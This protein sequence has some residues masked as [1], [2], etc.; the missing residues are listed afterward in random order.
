MKQLNIVCD[1]I[2]YAEFP[3]L[4]FGLDE[5]GNAY[6]DVD[7]YLQDNKLELTH[8]IIKFQ[9][10]FFYFLTKA[11]SAYNLKIEDIIA[12]NP[13]NE[14]HLLLSELALLFVMYTDPNFMFYVLDRIDE[15]FTSGITMS[16]T[17]L[18]QL[19]SNR[20]GIQENAA[21]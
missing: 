15:M 20:T 2:R 14:H 13:E 1:Q 3:D 8:D 16:D 11:Q 5:G 7:Q 12:I 19:S 6:C 9:Q 4:K 17:A 18:I 10:K 21:S